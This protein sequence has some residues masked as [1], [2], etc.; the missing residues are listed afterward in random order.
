M[1]CF[2]CSRCLIKIINYL[3]VICC[4]VILRNLHE[5]FDKYK[6]CEQV[7]SHLYSLEYLRWPVITEMAII[8][9]AQG[10]SKFLGRAE[11]VPLVKAKGIQQVETVLQWLKVKR[12]D[13]MAG[14][15]LAAFE[16]FSASIL[17]L[18]FITPYDSM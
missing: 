1:T 13:R 6:P 8:V 10:S 9:H 3:S 5:K 15:L 2:H 12:G 11:A 17:H 16:L 4:V 18:F 14:D 7:C